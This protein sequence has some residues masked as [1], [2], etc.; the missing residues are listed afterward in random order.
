MADEQDMGA[1]FLADLAKLK[2]E[3]KEHRPP[4][5]TKKEI[6]TAELT[7]D[8]KRIVIEYLLNG[9]GKGLFED[10]PEFWAAMSS[11]YNQDQIEELYP[12]MRQAVEK[13]VEQCKHHLLATIGEA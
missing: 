11:L 4:T 10:V 8:Q 5:F 3:K 6:P 12:A 9:V 7:G 1:D 13:F 2:I